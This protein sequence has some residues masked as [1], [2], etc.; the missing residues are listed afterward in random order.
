MRA[1]HSLMSFRRSL[2][3]MLLFGAL[4]SSM[5]SA[6]GTIPSP[7]TVGTD[8]FRKLVYRGVTGPAEASTIKSANPPFP[9]RDFSNGSA[10][11]LAV[12]L[13]DT[14]SEWLGIARGL[15]SI[16]VPFIVT[17]DA[18][19]ALRHR[20]IL[21]YPY[22]SGRALDSTSLRALAR[23]PINGGTLL[24]VTVLGAL[25]ET[26]GFQEAVPSRSRFGV[27][28]DRTDS[29]ARQFDDSLESDLRLGQRATQQQTTVATYGYTTPRQRPIATFD[30]GSA[31]ITRRDFEGGGLAVAFGIDIGYLLNRGYNNRDDYIYRSY[32][33]GFEPTLDV[34]LRFLSAVYA[35]GEPGAVRLGTVPGGRS[36]SL[37]LTHDIDY[38][39]S[40][41]NA[42][43]YAQAEKAAG[44]RATYFVQTKYITDW[45]DTAFFSPASI[46]AMR[47]VDSLGGRIASHS[48]SHTVAF[49]NIPTGTGTER[50]PDYWPKVVT[51]NTVRGATVLGELR[52]SRFLLESLG[53]DTLISFRPGHL[54]N[55]E[56][57][58]QALEAT[59][60]QFSSSTTANTSLTHLPYQLTFGRT[61]ESLSPIY[62]FPVTIEDEAQPMGRRLAP[63]L[64]IARRIARYGGTMNVLIHPNITG[65]KLEFQRGLVAALRDSAWIGALEDFATFWRA[66]DRVSVDV[67]IDRDTATVTV[68]S[69]EAIRGLPLELPASWRAA[70]RADGSAWPSWAHGILLD[71]PAG[72]TVLRVATRTR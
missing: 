60:F 61:S 55:P 12:L 11:R 56:S 21:V 62:E 67:A 72:R 7:A 41:R 25:N 5:L 58:P 52:V 1:T 66:R 29:L 2:H 50:Y 4:A 48:V 26:F 17:R 36:L 37:I 46:R 64:D 24:A 18:N 38:G 63:T 59:G 47:Q 49:R 20:V 14:I 6:Q 43:A 68:E 70:A 16:G 44:V 13:T 27:R 71:L 28:F 10:S 15:K 42:V 23:H 9:Y 8:R 45:N 22:V 35:R 69:P 19:E 33:N 54:R 65:E 51:R 31:A 3:V 30:D 39:V 53:G 34:F 32:V 57:L 40:M